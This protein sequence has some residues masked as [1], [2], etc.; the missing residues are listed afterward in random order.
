MCAE[1]GSCLS[2]LLAKDK[3]LYALLASV[4]RGSKVTVSLFSHVQ[5]AAIVSLQDRHRALFPISQDAGGNTMRVPVW[6]VSH[7]SSANID[8][9]RLRKKLA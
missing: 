2:A 7:C 1:A 9:K 4:L 6:P 3:V 8:W 5:Q